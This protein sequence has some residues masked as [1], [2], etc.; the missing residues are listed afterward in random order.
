MILLPYPDPIDPG[1]VYKLVSERTDRTY[2]MMVE[3]RQM[4][5]IIYYI[6][7]G[8]GLLI[9][10]QV[11]W[12]LWLD[13]RQNKRFKVL[14]SRAQLFL[15]MAIA[16]AEVT[17]RIHSRADET[18]KQ[19]EQVIPVLTDS[20]KATESSGPF[21]KFNKPAGDGGPCP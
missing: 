1:D 2:G 4:L 21:P 19:V 15:N 3:C 9:L 12:K 13:Y 7:I 10:F 20:V 16:H 14:E 18:L 6:S 17:D 8:V 5:E 11:L